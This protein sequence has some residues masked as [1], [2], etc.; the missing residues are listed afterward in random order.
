MYGA[1][2]LTHG[3]WSLTTPTD[4]KLADRTAA[5][6]RTLIKRP[7][8]PAAPSPSSGQSPGSNTPQKSRS[9]VQSPQES[10]TRLRADLAL[11]QKS[12]FEMQAALKPLTAELSA[13]RLSSNASAK[14]IADL[15]REKGGL[16][17]KLRDREEELKEK[18]RLVENVQDEMVS[19][20]L[21]LNMAEQTSEKLGKEN[22]EL[23]ERWMERMGKEANAMNDASKWS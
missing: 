8:S 15:Q 13:L 21:Q 1:I 10:L 16:E 17:R 19:L 3:N 9:D 20:N 14:Q 4:T 18:R 12:K 5:L 23:V 7:T 22:R 6:E 2:L 11:A